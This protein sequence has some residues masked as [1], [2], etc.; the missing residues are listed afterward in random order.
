MG[1]MFGRMLMGLTRQELLNLKSLIDD[2]LQTEDDQTDNSSE[3]KLK[4][5]LVPKL[6]PKLVPKLKPKLA[7]K[8]KPKE[9]S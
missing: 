7:P 9:G 8:L 1:E 3:P 6:K 2:I 5:K 4:P